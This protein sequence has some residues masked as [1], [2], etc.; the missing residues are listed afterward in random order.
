MHSPPAVAQPWKVHGDTANLGILAHQRDL[1]GVDEVHHALD[2]IL[3]VVR[4][5]HAS[6]LAWTRIA[7]LRLRRARR[8][9]FAG[10]S[11]GKRLGRIDVDPLAMADRGHAVAPAEQARVGCELAAAVD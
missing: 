5:A 7:V 9:G 2:P 6:T 10:A 11:H 3:G 4:W 1:M 8:P